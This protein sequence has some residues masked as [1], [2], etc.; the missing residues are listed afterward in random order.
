MKFQTLEEVAIETGLDETGFDEKVD[1][2]IQNAFNHKHDHLHV[3]LVPA[4]RQ[5]VKDEMLV[6]GVI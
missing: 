6:R 3:T 1:N 2:D 5:F 4:K